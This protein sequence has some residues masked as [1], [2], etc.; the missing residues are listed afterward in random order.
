[1]GTLRLAYLRGS[2]AEVRLGYAMPLPDRACCQALW[3]APEM[4]FGEGAL[5]RYGLTLPYYDG[6]LAYELRFQNV[7]RG[8]YH[9]ATGPSLSVS[10][11][12]R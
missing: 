7:L 3:V 1:M 10:A 2:Y 6:C 4:G 11:T 5:S 12:L 9:E 8:Q